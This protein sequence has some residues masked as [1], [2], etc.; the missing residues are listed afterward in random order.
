MAV[1]GRVGVR[2]KVIVVV[3]VGVGLVSTTPAHKTVPL[4]E[5]SGLAGEMRAK[6]LTLSPVS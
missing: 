5:D 4:V 6:S 3:S 1:G 2:V